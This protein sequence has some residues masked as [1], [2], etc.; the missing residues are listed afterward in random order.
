MAKTTIKKKKK[1][2]GIAVPGT[3]VLKRDIAGPCFGMVRVF[4]TL[5][6]DES[7]RTQYLFSGGFVTMGLTDE[8]RRAVCGHFE[9]KVRKHILDNRDAYGLDDESVVVVRARLRVVEFDS[10]VD[11]ERIKNELRI[12]S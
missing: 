7:V 6:I 10:F 11:V 1:A 2:A 8:E 9:G 4:A 12:K 3:S 5:K